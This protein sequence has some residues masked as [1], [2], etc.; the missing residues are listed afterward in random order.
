MRQEISYPPLRIP[1]AENLLRVHS[2]SLAWLCAS[3]MSLF[4]KLTTLWPSGAHPS[5]CH[6]A[7]GNTRTSPLNCVLIPMTTRVCCESSAKKKKIGSL[8][9]LCINLLFC[10]K[11]FHCIHRDGIQKFSFSSNEKVSGGG[12]TWPASF[13]NNEKKKQHDI[14]PSSFML[15]PE[16]FNPLGVANYKRKY[17][18]SETACS[19]PNFSLAWSQY[20]P[21]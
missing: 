8:D 10:N 15:V 9:H 5:C 11:S 19:L 14:A 4:R 16:G 7:M 18:N 17:L 1:A 20:L 12:S 21:S 6:S 2:I 3:G 13:G